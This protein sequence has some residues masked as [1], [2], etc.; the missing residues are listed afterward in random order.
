VILD[1]SELPAG[2][3]NHFTAGTHVPLRM[4]AEEMIRISDNSATDILIHTLGREQIE[5][6]EAHVGIRDPAANQPF[7]STM[8]AFK[9]KGVGG[10]EL[11]R[12][13]LSLNET[14]RRNYLAGEVAKSPGSAIGALFAGGKPV[15]IDH[16]EWFASPADLV[17]VMTWLS[18]QRETRGGSEA[19]RI[20]AIN[21]GP[22][23]AWVKQFAYVGYKG[24]SEPG[25]LSMTLLLRDIGGRETVISTSW[26]NDKS[27]VDELKF[28]GLVTRA[29]ELLSTS[30]MPK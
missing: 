5:T 26:N 9:L 14:R 23:T 11:G 22:A 21:P 25:V 10:G 24:G 19:L 30:S 13:Y 15:M 1:G 16:I 2:G 27:A 28:S 18:K 6:M 17:R 7:L 8:E 12:R 4:L 3:F 29:I 20:L